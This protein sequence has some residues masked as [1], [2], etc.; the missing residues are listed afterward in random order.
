MAADLRETLT[1]DEIKGKF[2]ESG[3]VVKVGSPEELLALSD[4]QYKRWGE[5][6][7]KTKIK[8]D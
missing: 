3:W 8:P 6:I 1:S 7:A 2:A 5:V 4:A